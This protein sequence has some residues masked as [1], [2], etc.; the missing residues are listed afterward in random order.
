VPAVELDFLLEDDTTPVRHEVDADIDI[1]QLRHHT[2]NA[3]QRIM[4]LV[5][6][7]PGL[8]DTPQGE[9]IA[10]ELERR[11]QLSAWISD[12]LFGLTQAPASMTD[13][14]RSLCSNVVELLSDPTQVVQIGVSV[15]GDCPAHLRDTVLRITHE[16][17]AN[18]MKHGMRRRTRGR[19]T[20]RLHSEPSGH[21]RLTVIDDGNGF[22]G[23]PRIGEGLT[24]AQMLADEFGGT[25]SV[26]SDG[27][28]T[29][30]LDMPPQGTLA[31][32]GSFRR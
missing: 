30:V 24:V 28:T 25:L 6:Q 29:A 23:K 32:D 17:V 7:A 1:R 31:A 13:R 27:R 11:I 12:A 22:H 18:A 21:T 26:R 16:L 10:R 4:G 5:S 2:K 8:C 3:L 14:L 20:V 9:H 15:R 19:I